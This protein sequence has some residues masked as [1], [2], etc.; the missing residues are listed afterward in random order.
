MQIFQLQLKEG[1]IAKDNRI[2]GVLFFLRDGLNVLVKRL[3]LAALEFVKLLSALHKFEE[4][5]SERRLFD[6]EPVIEDEVHDAP[7]CTLN[8]PA[9]SHSSLFS[10]NSCLDARFLF[11]KRVQLILNDSVKNHI[12]VIKLL[13]VIKH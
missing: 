12:R 1:T 9:F 3:L 7:V 13:V 8:Q 2:L 11:A 5:A 10:D 4:F 6:W